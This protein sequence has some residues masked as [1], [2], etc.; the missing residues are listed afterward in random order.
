[1]A[2]NNRIYRCLFVRGAGAGTV[3]LVS[4][5]VLTLAARKIITSLVFGDLLEN[6]SP[7][8]CTTGKHFPNEFM[9][10]SHDNAPVQKE[11]KGY[12]RSYYIR[13]LNS[14]FSSSHSK[15][16]SIRPNS[17]LQVC[18]CVFFSFLGTYFWPG[19]KSKTKSYAVESQRLSGL[20]ISMA[21]NRLDCFSHQL[22]RETKRLLLRHSSIADSFFF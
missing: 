2:F 22:T 17:V 21:P 9:I 19:L 20:R 6:N 15:L 18:V 8:Y 1:M 4:S 16:I 5:P 12:M 11:T 13:Q 7:C 3:V 10:Y 14:K